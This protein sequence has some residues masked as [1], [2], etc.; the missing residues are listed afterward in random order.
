MSRII[1]HENAIVV[2][3]NLKIFTKVSVIQTM[4]L[5]GNGSV[6]IVDV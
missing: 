1:T 5:H 2:V 4:I 6:I 3:K